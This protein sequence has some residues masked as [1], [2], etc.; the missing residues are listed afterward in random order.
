MSSRAMPQ[1]PRAAPVGPAVPVTVETLAKVTD[2]C[3]RIIA[4]KAGLTR[5]ALAKLLDELPI[6]R[7]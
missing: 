5:A 2:V 1:P 3:E 7:L 4:A 6:L